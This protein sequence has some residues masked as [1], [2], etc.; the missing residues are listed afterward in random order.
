M[1][2]KRKLLLIG[3]DAADW[4]LIH[5]LMD[6]GMMPTLKRLVE[7]GSAG[8]LA[9]L[10]PPMSPIMWTSIATGM[11]ADK[12]GILNFTEPDPSNQGIRPVS[13][14]SRKKKAIWNMLMQE[15]YKVHTV[16]WWPSHPSEPVNGISISNFYPHITKNGMM[17]AEMSKGT[18][19]PES[20]ASTFDQLRL[21]PHE[22]TS[23]HLKPFIPNLDQVDQKADRRVGSVAK[24]LAEAATVHNAATWIMENEA[25]DF[26]AVYHTAIDH[27]GHG[28]MKYHPPRQ[29]QVPEADFETYQHVVRSGYKFHDMMLARMI[30]L[31]G[32][33]TTVVIVSDHGF[34]SDHLLKVAPPKEPAGPAHQHRPYG[35]M[36]MNGEGIKQDE[37]IFGAS[38][39]DVTP[40]LLTLLGLPVGEDMDGKTLV[41]VFEDDRT[42]DFISSWEDREGSDGRHPSDKYIDPIAEQEALEQLIALGYVDE[43]EKDV[44]E[45]VDRTINESQ[46]FLARALMDK[47]QYGKALPILEELHEK[48]PDA[49]RFTF[50]LAKCYQNLGKIAECRFAVE[51]ISSQIRS[52]N[53]QLNLLEGS[54]ALA[55]QDYELA[56]KHFNTAEAHSPDLP[57]LHQQI[58]NAYLSL[59]KPDDAARAFNHALNLDPENHIAL[60]GLAEV[61]LQKGDYPRALDYGLNATGLIYNYPRAHFNIGEAL[62]GMEEFERASQAY[63]VTMSITPNFILPRKGVVN[64][65]RNKLDQKDKARE[66]Q[67]ILDQLKEQ[68]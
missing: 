43:P 36:V 65:Y 67:L 2:A 28:F 11:H 46:Y 68:K 61:Y 53:P 29:P 1:M 64:L 38:L 57:S 15:N 10:D 6:A 22:L 21:F 49:V 42:P 30:Q 19:H 40:T 58:G 59:K 35:I 27:F 41:Q 62:L 60:N 20:M 25:W 31:A 3:W 24:I 23:A 9:T 18:V 33:D 5:P 47:Q 16:G 14:L 54:L 4:K 7:T 66:H 12:H 50:R 32:P 51:E 17:P 44:A 45:T 39:L 52:S 13:G 55:E 48:D 26:L 56:L 37:L 34:H 63:E 8:N